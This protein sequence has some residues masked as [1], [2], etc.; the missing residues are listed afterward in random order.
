M[1]LSSGGLPPSLPS[2]RV[3]LLVVPGN[4][5]ELHTVNPEQQ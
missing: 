3:D 1:D 2:A 4:R 5:L